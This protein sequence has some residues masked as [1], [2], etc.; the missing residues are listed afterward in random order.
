MKKGFWDYSGAEMCQP[1][2]DQ[3]AISMSGDLLMR[4]SDNMAINMETGNID[5]I[6]GWEE[7]CEE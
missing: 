7:D 1:I 2:S 6:S 5:L 3:M 4:M